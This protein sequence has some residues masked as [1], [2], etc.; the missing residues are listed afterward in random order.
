MNPIG[1]NFNIPSIGKLNCTYSRWKGV[2]QR[3]KQLM[4]LKN[5]NKDKED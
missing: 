3:Y 1:T 2:K 5:D 4:K